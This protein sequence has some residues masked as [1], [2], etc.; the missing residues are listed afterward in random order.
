MASI[1]RQDLINAGIRNGLTYDQTNRMLKEQGFATGYNPLLQAE[2]YKQLGKNFRR[3]AS[4]MARDLRSFGGYLLTPVN[5]V[6]KDVHYAK[7]G[8]KLS[9]A[10]KAFQN[11]I[12]DDKYRKTL[13]GA[14]AGAGVGTAIPKVGTL[15]GLLLGA[16]LGINNG[17]PK[18]L[19]NDV[20]A[21]YDISTD[22]YKQRNIKDVIQGAFRNPLYTALDTAPLTGRG[23][24]KIAQS[25][26][27]NSPLWARQLLPDKATRQF[28]RQISNSIVNAKE[29][30]YGNY[31]GYLNLQEAPYA[32]REK[33]LK[34][35]V[36]NK[37]DL[38][39]QEQLLADVIKTNLRDVENNFI[40][41]G[42][43]DRKLFKDNAI[44]QYV[45]YNLPEG[46]QLVH[47][48]IMNI[49]NGNKLRTGNQVTDSLINKINKLADEG[50]KLYD[51]KKI[52]F[53]T[54]QLMPA[55]D[56]NINARDIVG[57]VPKGY[58]DTTR[59]LGS[60]DLGKLSTV[61][62]TSLKHQLDQFNKYMEVED[63]ISDLVKNYN[64]ER[65]SP[66]NIGLDIPE[67][68]VALS[69][70][71]FKNTVKDSFAKGDDIDVVEALNKSKVKKEGSYIVDKL[72]L[73]MINNAFDKKKGNKVLNSFKKTV[74]ANPH[75][76]VL[77]RVGNISNNFID[78]VTV[79]DYADA[80]KAS[81]EGVIPR[82]LQ[83]QTSFN[84]YVN[85]L[86]NGE[87]YVANN[88]MFSRAL[89]SMKTPIS[90]FKS[91]L[92]K[93][94]NSRQGL[95][96]LGKLAAS[97]YS[98]SSDISANP[99][100]KIESSLEYLDRS[101]NM[102]RQAKRLEG[103]LGK[104]W[105]DILKEANT[106]NEL[107]SMLNDGVNKALGDYIGRN[108]ALPKG[109]YDFASE[110]IPFYRFYTQT[111]RTTANQLMNNPVGFA[112][113][114]TIPARV[115]NYISED[116]I[117][118]Y[119]LDRDKYAGG[120]P[121]LQEGNNIRTIGYEPL[122]IASVLEMLGN[123]GE[124]KNLT[125]MLSPYWS[126][127]PEALMFKKFGRTATSPRQDEME[128]A[129]LHSEVS[130]YQPTLGETLS[131][132]LNSFGQTTY[133]PYRAV[134]SWL[135]EI[136]ATATGGGIQSRYDTNSMRQRHKSYKR[137][138][139]TELAGKQLGIQTYSNYPNKKKN[140]RKELRDNRR[141]ANYYNQEVERNKR[142]H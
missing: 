80:T 43:G 129:G 122:P 77:N 84:S 38:T 75:W 32:S 2:N 41:R 127:F 4:E 118:K 22:N 119:G 111:L 81:K 140:T 16:S 107:F 46:T 47:D 70:E 62:D 137:T 138:L 133:H 73:D 13:A 48:D 105:K 68:K 92:N 58:F 30:N 85:S 88:N 139:P 18:K 104:N 52:S 45:M 128:Q 5:E 72:Y 10:K 123:V 56:V 9:S 98:N 44:S 89:S 31:E 110:A 36:T 20:L 3:N 24:G 116:V 108:Y 99:W 100:Y 60:Q 109:L 87:N 35:I 82:Q 112:S 101:A 106:N 37:G 42:Y 117:N 79:F 126:T 91:D 7:T 130:K 86:M 8:D 39:K 26:P 55:R 93:F 65:L 6:S 97:I 33:I 63:T 141:Y 83:Q 134:T 54:Q 78:G 102:V 121:Y 142:K 96:D 17:D 12:N 125:Q 120:I 103:A 29:K 64:I 23:I 124:G 53:F 69:L 67:S 28:N 61:F 90:K 94:K 25:I 95:G 113:N 34:N 131:Y 1:S 59:V 21:T 71:N 74:L 50:G 76:L 57:T 49:I 66:D 136:L 135:P 114:V 15:G 51:D 19:L 27:E 40:E 14:V 132:M 115:G 11:A